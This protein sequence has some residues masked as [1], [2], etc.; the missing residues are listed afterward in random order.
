[1]L[2]GVG[3]AHEAGVL[4]RDLKPDNLL[5]TRARDGQT[6]VKILD[7]G[8]AKFAHPQ[9]VAASGV[10]ESVTTPGA[11]MGTFGYMSPEQ[12]VGG[13]ADERSDLFAVAVMVAEALTGQPP[14]RGRTCQE[15]LASISEG[16]SH[17][18]HQTDAAR[19]LDGV[20]HRC[21]AI[22]R[23]QRYASAEEMRR[24]LVPALRESRSAGADTAK[25][26]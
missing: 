2:E 6:Q 13:T 7:F 4:H 23:E 15:L 22:D 21:L 11:V 1:V 19:R 8:L 24:E 5:P 26:N 20:L 25:Q 10:S 14:F 16:W 12:L 3:A 17:L 9:E 18:P